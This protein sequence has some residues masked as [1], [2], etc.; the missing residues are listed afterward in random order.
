MK[1]FKEYV[2][3]R[4]GFDGGARVGDSVK[5]SDQEALSLLYKAAKLMIEKDPQALLG[6]LD[7]HGDEEIKRMIDRI[8]QKKL[9]MEPGFGNLGGDDMERIKT[10]D[11]DRGGSPEEDEEGGGG[12]GGN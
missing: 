7:S 1:K 12:G 2:L 6:F 9:N 10:P 11:A 5:D 3:Y 4:D 8:R